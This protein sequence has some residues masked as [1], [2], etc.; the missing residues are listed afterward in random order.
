MN[1]EIGKRFPDLELPD[2]EGKNVKLSE[3]SGGFPLIVAFYRAYW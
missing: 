3:L 1:Q 2:E